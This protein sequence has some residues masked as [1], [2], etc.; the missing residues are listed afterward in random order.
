MIP[1]LSPLL[2]RFKF[3]WLFS[4]PKVEDRVDGLTS[5][6]EIQEAMTRKLNSISK[7]DFSKAIGTLEERASIFVQYNWKYFEKNIS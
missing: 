6:K 3:L 7:D 1:V 2:T 5:I 4:I